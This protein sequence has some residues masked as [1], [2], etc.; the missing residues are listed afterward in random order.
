[1]LL[2][3]KERLYGLRN[4]LVGWVWLSIGLTAPLPM[5]SLDKIPHNWDQQ[6]ALASL[7]WNRD[8]GTAWGELCMASFTHGSAQVAQFC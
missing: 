6:A 2:R 8:M 7:S 4:T 5:H 3:R 1:M